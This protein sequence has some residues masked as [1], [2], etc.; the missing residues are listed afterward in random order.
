MKLTDRSTAENVGEYC[1][2]FNYIRPNL[3]TCFHELHTAFFKMNEIFFLNQRNPV[4]LVCAYTVKAI[5]S[6]G[7]FQETR[8]DR[9]KLLLQI[10]ESSNCLW[11]RGYLGFPKDEV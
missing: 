4:F 2:L 5:Y 1:F 10:L 6:S 3:F 11:P 8:C 9:F 7:F